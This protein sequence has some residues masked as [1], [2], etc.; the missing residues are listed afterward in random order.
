MR[1]EPTTGLFSSRWSVILADALPHGISICILKGLGCQSTVIPTSCLTNSHSEQIFL[2]HFFTMG[3]WKFSDFTLGLNQTHNLWTFPNFS[4]TQFFNQQNG[5]KWINPYVLF[6]NS[7]TP[8]A[9]P[10]RVKA[11]SLIIVH[12]PW[13]IRIYV[14]SKTHISSPSVLQTHLSVF[15]IWNMPGMFSPKGFWPCCSLFLA[16]SCPNCSFSGSLFS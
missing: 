4:K 16:G 12:K 15:Q 11:E 7:S 8:T 1:S 3:C 14:A 10:L 13:K 2:V 9:S 6:C 5:G